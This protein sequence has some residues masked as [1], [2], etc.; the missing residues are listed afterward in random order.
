MASNI[1]LD[2]EAHL[3][4]LENSLLDTGVRKSGQINELLADDYMEFGSSG[5]TYTKQQVLAALKNEPPRDFRA[6]EFKAREFIPG[7]VL[8]SYRAAHDNIRTLRTSLW[9]QRGGRWQ[10]VFHQGVVEP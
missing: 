4:D 8:V 2:V 5:A 1:K 9:Q 3:I 7:N 10:L 6:S